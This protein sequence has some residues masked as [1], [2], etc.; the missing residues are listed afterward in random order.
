M[1]RVLKWTGIILG[2]IIGLIILTGL[3]IYGASSWKLSK[4]YDINPKQVALPADSAA[5]A[6]GRHIATT[7]GCADCHGEDLGGKLFIDDPAIGQLYGPNLT[8]GQGG[9]STKYSNEDWV[10]ALRHGVGQEGTSLLM[11]P[12]Y[13]YY[14]LSDKDLGS[15][16]AY[17]K[18]LAPVNREATTNRLGP[19][20]RMLVTTGDMKLAAE[21]IDHDAPRPETPSPGPTAAYGAYLS[22]SCTGCHGSDFRGGPIPASPPAWP[23]AANLTPHADD[24]IGS[25][26]QADF[27]RA[28]REGQRP[29]GEKI[30]PVMP[31]AMGKMTDTELTALWKYLQSLPPQP[32][33]K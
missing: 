7:R 25:W 26:S 22:A 21:V 31:A 27:F 28:L 5:V 16:I 29:N 3:G 6:W 15:L 1:R 4:S 24:G 14:H 12:S 11:M 33:P 18:Q 19:V 13:E 2:S 10:R 17:L 9:I 23:P 30:N 20:G 8:S 32:D